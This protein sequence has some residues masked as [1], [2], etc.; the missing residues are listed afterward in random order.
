MEKKK[1]WVL[2]CVIG[3]LLLAIGISFA[4]WKVLLQ[5]ES[6][7]VVN[8]SCLK[9]ELQDQNEISLENAVPIANS[10]IPNPNKI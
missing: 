2:V 1:A 4:F 6:V 5:Q 7:N 9:L 3:I 8:S 10:N